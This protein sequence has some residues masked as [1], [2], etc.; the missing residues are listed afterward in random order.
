[1]IRVIFQFT[2]RISRQVKTRHIWVFALE[3]LA[4]R[5]F[6]VTSGRSLNYQPEN[7]MKQKYEIYIF[8]IFRTIRE[9]SM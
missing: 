4:K 2:V 1:M 6:Y 9:A 8:Y 5:G 7:E 3:E